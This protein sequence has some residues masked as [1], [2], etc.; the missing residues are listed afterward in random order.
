MDSNKSKALI[1]TVLA[2]LV[3][4]SVSNAVQSWGNA[5]VYA[6]DRSNA[7]TELQD[8]E[9]GLRG[10]EQKDWFCSKAERDDIR[11]RLLALNKA[12]VAAKVCATEPPSDETLAE[13]E[14][15]GNIETACYAEWMQAVQDKLKRFQECKSGCQS[16]SD[17][18]GG[19]ACV[20]NQ[21]WEEPSCTTSQECIGWFGQGYFCSEGKC[22]IEAECGVDSDCVAEHGQGYQCVNGNC[23]RKS[24][25]KIQVPE[26]AQ[27]RNRFQKEEMAPEKPEV[28]ELDEETKQKIKKWTG[29]DVDDFSRDM[30]TGKKAY[31]VISE[32]LSPNKLEMVWTYKK[33][34]YMVAFM[35][36]VGYDVRLVFRGSDKDVFD[37][38]ADPN[39]GAV[40]YFGHSGEPAIE[41]QDFDSGGLET[42]LAASRGE[43][44][45]EG[46]MERTAARKK[47]NSEES[48]GL[49]FFYNHACHSADPGFENM[50]DALVRPG[51]VYYGEDGLLWATNP[52]GTEYVRP[53]N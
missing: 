34:Q 12:N 48:M 32:T 30:G 21:C 33:V 27:V 41:D 13:M 9:N 8:C 14:A 39:A 40:A 49:D 35:Q 37:A 1:L 23:L 43:W 16:D 46:G 31:V 20:E 10:L 38:V 22:F 18:M 53:F 51:G 15:R 17:C 11:E 24:A 50:A 19:E 42:Q 2:I 6:E 47:A 3:L 5:G 29:L 26:K 45:E 52:P 25:E 36:H 7:L 4:M 44:Y 28:P